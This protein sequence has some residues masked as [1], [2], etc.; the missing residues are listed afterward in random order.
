MEIVGAVSRVGVVA[1]SFALHAYLIKLGQKPRWR[2]NDVDVF[3]CAQSVT[4]DKAID[5][6][7]TS[8][9]VSVEADFDESSPY[10][11]SMHIDADDEVHYPLDA[12]ASYV[13]RATILNFVSNE[14]EWKKY[15]WERLWSNRIDDLAPNFNIHHVS[16]LRTSFKTVDGT[17]SGAVNVI[18][19]DMATL[20]GRSVTDNF[21]LACCA[22]SCCV[23]HET[24]VFDFRDIAYCAVVNKKMVV[25]PRAF[26]NFVG[27]PDNYS[28]R[29]QLKRI[30]KYAS[31]GFEIEM[32][33]SNE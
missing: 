15:N 29:K 13:D 18:F 20:T 31:R 4:L 11:V 21:D 5:E 8:K 30:R 7:E 23:L 16:L 24:L 19:T 32:L 6:L 9:I 10:P 2:A 26:R 25:M 28:I 17:C 22:F 33:P 1:G 14:T 12:D 27:F 3:V